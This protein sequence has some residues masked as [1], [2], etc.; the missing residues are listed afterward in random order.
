MKLIADNL[1]ITKTDIKEALKVRDPRP[2]Q[3]LVHQCVTKGRIPIDI[4]K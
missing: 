1:R 2:A 4:V 3:D